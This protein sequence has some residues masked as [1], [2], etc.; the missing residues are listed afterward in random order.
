MLREIFSYEYE[1]LSIE[2]K[3][4]RKNNRSRK[5]DGSNVVTRTYLSP[6]KF[7]WSAAASLSRTKITTSFRNSRCRSLMFFLFS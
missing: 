2:R 4:K 6:D 1:L 5:L 3:E 7:K